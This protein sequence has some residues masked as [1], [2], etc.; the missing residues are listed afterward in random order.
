M[1]EEAY[2]IYD[3][4]WVL[5]LALHRTDA[6]VKS[7]NIEGTGCENALGSLVPLINF[8]YS[9]EKIGCLIRWNIQQTNFSGLTVREYCITFR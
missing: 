2:R 1:I 6:M 7:Q 8:S 5:A 9:N 4:M 3:V